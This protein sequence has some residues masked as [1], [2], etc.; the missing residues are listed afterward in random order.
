MG[1]AVVP[2]PSQ[3]EF[4]GI[5]SSLYPMVTWSPSFAITMAQLQSRM[6]SLVLAPKAVVSLEGR[7]DIRVR[8]TRWA[9]RCRTN[10]RSRRRAPHPCS[11]GQ[12]RESL[13]F[14]RRAWRSAV[15]W[16]SRRHPA[17]T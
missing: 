10:R 16:W 17:R 14:F 15:G 12:P 3:A 7:I 5:P 11:A 4:N 8:N 2:E 9:P 1:A 13:C 6:Q